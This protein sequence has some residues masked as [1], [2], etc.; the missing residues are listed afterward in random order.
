[1]PNVLIGAHRGISAKKINLQIVIFQLSI[2][3][4]VLSAILVCLLYDTGCLKSIQ[5]LHTTKFHAFDTSCLKNYTK[6]AHH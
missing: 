5:K 6:V 4:N 1:M 2:S 3:D